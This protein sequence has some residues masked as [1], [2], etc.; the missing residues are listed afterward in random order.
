MD[1]MSI[2]ELLVH[3]LK[4]KYVGYNDQYKAILYAL[5]VDP[6]TPADDVLLALS[7]LKEKS[8]E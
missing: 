1:P 3:R 2:F 4:P 6:D 8:D 7:L 5:G